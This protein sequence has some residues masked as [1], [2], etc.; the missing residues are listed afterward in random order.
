MTADQRTTLNQAGR[1]YRRIESALDWMCVNYQSQPRL[2]DVADKA[3]LSEFHF[4]R[5]FHRWVGLSPKKFIQYLTLRRAKQCLSKSQTVLDATYES[6]LSSPGRLHDLFVNMESVTPGEFKSHGRGMQIVYGVHDTPYSKWVVAKNERGVC[7]LRFV[8][9]AG[10]DQALVEL[11]A[12]FENAQ[13]TEDEAV[14][15]QL[16]EQIF[17]ASSHTAPI[18]ALVRGTAFELKVWE[19]LLTIP[20]GAVTTY[21]DVARRIGHPKSARAVGNA[22][23]KNPLAYLIP[24]H[25]VIQ[26]SGVLGGYRWGTPRKLGMLT[27]ELT[28][29]FDNL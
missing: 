11:E 10:I 19:A 6:G 17:G 26:R 3:G 25:R 4:Q 28:A 14:A 2:S 8:S 5:L 18:T 23:G 1:D 12:G 13:W 16:T 15:G 9:E 20:T 7:G 27:R 24:C 22:I 29:G 21:A